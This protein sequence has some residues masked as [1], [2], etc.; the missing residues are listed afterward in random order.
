MDHWKISFAIHLKK[1]GRCPDGR[2]E[3]IPIN[4]LRRDLEYGA[5]IVSGRGAV[6]RW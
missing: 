4:D 2:L 5:S 1:V 6:T 3:C